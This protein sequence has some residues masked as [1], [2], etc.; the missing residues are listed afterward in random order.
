MLRL[1]LFT[2]LLAPATH[3]LA[4]AEQGQLDGSPALFS[5]LA[6]INAAGYDADLD[7]PANHPLRAAV[8]KV[9]VTG[10]MDRKT[11]AALRK[12]Q[13]KRGLRPNAKVGAATWIKLLAREPRAVNWAARA[14]AANAGSGPNGPHSA[15]LPAKGYEIPP[16]AGAG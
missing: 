12:F 13:R 4:A 1:L 7:S 9:P 2:S 8:R 11:I 5:V 15:S 16:S 6:A 14:T 3:R 10:V